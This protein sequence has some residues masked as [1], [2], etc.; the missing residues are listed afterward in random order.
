MD[1]QL[2]YAQYKDFSG[3]DRLEDVSGYLSFA[4]SYEDFD[5][6]NGVVWHRNSLDWDN[7]FDLTSSISW[8]VNED[9]TFTLK[10]ENLLNKA[11]STSQATVNWATNPPEVGALEISPIDQR[12]IFELEYIF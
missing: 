1:L 8:N 5:F 11:K 2:Y 6:Y 9:L 10:G 3:V 4:N 12:V 7:Y